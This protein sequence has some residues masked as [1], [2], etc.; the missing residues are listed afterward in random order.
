[1][2]N[3]SSSAKYLQSLRG[4][5]GSNFRAVEWPHAGI[6]VVVV[7]I[8]ACDVGVRICVIEGRGFGD[9]GGRRG[10]EVE[11]C[12]GMDGLMEGGVVGKGNKSQ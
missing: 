2:N 3:I 6:V 4:W 8:N 5:V 9:V 12:F 11:D 7:T 10:D 1:M